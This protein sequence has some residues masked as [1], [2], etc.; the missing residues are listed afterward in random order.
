[1]QKHALNTA[2]WRKS[3]H[4]D[5][6]NGNCLEVAD[7]IPGIVPVRDSKA[8]PHGPVVTVTPAAWA[9]FLSGV[10]CGGGASTPM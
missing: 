8:G 10:A 9:A 2:R 3:S 1:M 7:G 4:S 6:N 5:D